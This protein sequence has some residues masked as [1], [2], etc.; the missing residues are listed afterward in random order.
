MMM[1]EGGD[2]VCPF[3]RCSSI[4]VPFFAQMVINGR[5]CGMSGEGWRMIGCNCL[6][7]GIIK[8]IDKTIFV[9]FWAV[10]RIDPFNNVLWN[11]KS[12]PCIQRERKVSG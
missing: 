5:P 4:F 8:L 11:K 10:S 1:C 9:L 6:D 2:N 3:L 7:S 12:S